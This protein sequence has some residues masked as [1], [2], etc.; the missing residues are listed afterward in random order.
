MFGIFGIL[1][2]ITNLGFLWLASHDANLT[3]MAVV[4][5]LENLAGGMGTAAF[6]ALLMTLCDSRFTATQF[7]LLSALPQLEEF[8]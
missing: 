7:A 4:I 6:V 3:G 5:I 8:L 1:Q 2:A